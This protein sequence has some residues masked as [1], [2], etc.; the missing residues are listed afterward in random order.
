[1][2]WWPI[3]LKLLNVASDTGYIWKVLIIWICY[4]FFGTFAIIG[5]KV[6]MAYLKE[7]R[8]TSL[9][10]QLLPWIELLW[11]TQGESNKNLQDVIDMNTFSETVRWNNR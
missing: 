8:R 9:E 10:I 4:L 3:K 11:L 6:R 1:M 7:I 5:I 2:K